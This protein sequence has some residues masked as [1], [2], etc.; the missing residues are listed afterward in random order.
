MAE[1]ILVKRD[2]PTS[3]AQTK[4]IIRQR[5]ISGQD[6]L[7][8]PEGTNTNR[9]MLIRFKPGAFYPGVPIQ[10]IF[11]KYETDDRID[12][13][14]WTWDGPSMSTILFLTLCKFYTSL[15]IIRF[16]VYTPKDEELRN[17]NVF[18][19][20]V[21]KKVCEWSKTRSSL[22]SFDDTGYFLFAKLAKVPRS[23]VGS[24][25]VKMVA[26]IL[27]FYITDFSVAQNQNRD[28]IM[29]QLANWYMRQEQIENRQPT[30]DR[31]RDKLKELD[32]RKGIA[33]KQV[34]YYAVIHVI[35]K[36]RAKIKLNHVTR[37]VTQADFNLI[38][39]IEKGNIVI[40]RLM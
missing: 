9:E 30:A 25:F 6:V 31:F 38:L 20:N 4:E 36:A 11:L 19:D 32:N 29:F 27:I 3:R 22:F 7:I 40:M 24:K 23:P 15:K 14:S 18:R 28:N 34:L 12:N 26:K 2:C 10:T 21:H 39:G 35:S 8:L 17:A 1:P 13:L 37:I 16:P 33:E 5:A